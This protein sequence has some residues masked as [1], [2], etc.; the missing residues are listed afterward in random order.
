LLSH[1]VPLI[2]LSADNIEHDGGRASL[3]AYWLYRTVLDH[4]TPFRSGGYIFAVKKE[5]AHQPVFA[6]KLPAS[7]VGARALFDEVFA[8]PDLRAAPASWGA[9]IKQLQ[10]RMTSESLD[11]SDALRA[12]ASLSKTGVLNKNAASASKRFDVLVLRLTCIGPSNAVLAWESGASGQ[13]TARSTQF[14]AQTGTMIVPLG[15]FPSWVLSP[16]DASLSLNAPDCEITQAELRQ[17][18]LP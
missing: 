2:L 4:Y 8:S 15:S 10:A 1:D 5:Y 9:S 17:R 12:N 14:L 3:R 16:S 18:R 13:G 7:D 6:D 11:V